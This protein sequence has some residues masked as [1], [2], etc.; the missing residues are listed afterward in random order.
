RVF[1]FALRAIIAREIIEYG[2][3]QIRHGAHQV[4]TPGDYIR[5]GTIYLGVIARA[6]ADFDTEAVAVCHRGY[7]DPVGAPIPEAAAPPARPV[8]PA[9]AAIEIWIIG[10]AHHCLG[11]LGPV[12]ERHLEARR[13]ARPRLDQAGGPDA[14]AHRVLVGLVF[15]V[16]GLAGFGIHE[17]VGLADHVGGPL[18]ERRDAGLD[19]GRGAACQ[20]PGRQRDRYTG[21]PP[22]TE[23]R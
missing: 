10:A 11:L 20:Q 4:F 3:H 16:A 18:L 1:H 21:P 22:E 9:I 6:I 8:K 19:R 7:V 15:Q 14:G 2:A 23:P 13:L 12:L 5:R 17:P